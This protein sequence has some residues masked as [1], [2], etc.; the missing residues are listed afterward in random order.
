MLSRL[1]P[2]PLVDPSKPSP[3][4]PTARSSTGH[5]HPVRCMDVAGSVPN[6]SNSPTALTGISETSGIRAEVQVDESGFD[7]AD[8]ISRQMRDLRDHSAIC[9]RQSSGRECGVACCADTRKLTSAFPR[10]LMKARP[11]ASLIA[12][13][14]RARHLGTQANHEPQRQKSATP[15]SPWCD[16]GRQG[17]PALLLRQ[18]V[19]KPF[20]IHSPIV[21]QISSP[22]MGWL[23]S[24]RTPAPL[25][26]PYM[27]A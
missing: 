2:R 4:Q 14:A 20:C 1:V 27:P 11:P 3:V 26:R 16:L 10:C 18:A 21:A 17:Q 25:A 8:P 19:R 12:L 9:S 24:A 7:S 13:S 15:A 23:G 5:G 6:M 22:K